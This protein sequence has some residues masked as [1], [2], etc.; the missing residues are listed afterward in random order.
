[1]GKRKNKSK[2]DETVD[3]VLG[4]VWYTR[5][6]YERLLKLANDRGDLEDTYEE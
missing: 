3:T 5:E 4:V 2:S 6:Q 1:M